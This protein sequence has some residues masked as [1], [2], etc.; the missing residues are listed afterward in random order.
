LPEEPE[1]LTRFIESGFI[2]E[3]LIYRVEQSLQWHGE[4]PGLADR[5]FYGFF[6]DEGEIE[7]GSYPKRCCSF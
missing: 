5:L 4:K 2:A 7:P 1:W 3:P 6:C